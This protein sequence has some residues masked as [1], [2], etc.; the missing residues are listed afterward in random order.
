MQPY[1]ISFNSQKSLYS[2]ISKDLQRVFKIFQR[3]QNALKLAVRTPAS[4]TFRKIIKIQKAVNILIYSLF[5]T[6]LIKQNQFKS[7]GRW[8][9]KVNTYRFSV[10][11]NPT[12][13]IVHID[14]DR[15]PAMG[16]LLQ[17]YNQLGQTIAFRQIDQ[18]NSV[19]DLSAHP[20]GMYYIKV[21][22]DGAT[23]TEKIILR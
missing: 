2:M 23:Q 6:S 18:Q 11:P 17:V 3:F 9:H 15:L 10:Y 19:I 14:F 4:S 21:N 5:I 22:S 7:K 8:A 1:A 13:G 20:A 12:G 16:T